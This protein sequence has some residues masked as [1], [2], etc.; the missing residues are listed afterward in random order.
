M[1]FRDTGRPVQFDDLQE[2]IRDINRAKRN[3]ETQRRRVQRLQHVRVSPSFWERVAEDYRWELRRCIEHL[4]SRK[5]EKPVQNNPLWCVLVPT[6]HRVRKKPIRVRE[7]RVWDSKVREIAGGLTIL[8]PA[9]GQWVG[10]EGK[11][12]VDRM[13]PVLVSCKQVEFDQVI[14]MTAHFYDEEAVMGWKISDTA[15]IFPNPE[16]TKIP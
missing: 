5:K 2:I 11:L 16:A 10:P 3:A 12:W 9:R 8:Q 6:V 7:H 15:V 13:I 4:K 1:N 14:A